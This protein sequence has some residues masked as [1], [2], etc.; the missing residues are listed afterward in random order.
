MTQ[1]PARV[2]VSIDVDEERIRAIVREE[3]AA[4]PATGQDTVAREWLSVPRAAK[5][6][7]VG[8]KRVKRAIRARRVRTR[9]LDPDRP[10]G[11]LEVFV[12]SLREALD[13]ASPA[14][15]DAL[16]WAKARQ[17]RGGK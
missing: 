4:A 6:C 9:P 7:G 12:P 15:T 8:V 5:A 14:P 10:D 16:A 13:G 17:A 11:R 1:P 2:T 3:L